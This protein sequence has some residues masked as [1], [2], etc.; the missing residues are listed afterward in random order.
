M[1]NPFTAGTKI[2][3]IQ[4]DVLRPLYTMYPGQEA[5]KFS[6]LLVE[7]GRAI[8]HH[9]PFME[10]VCRS[11]LV[12][13]IFKII[14]LLGGADQLTEEDF[15]RFTSYVNDG[16][17][18]AMVKMLLSADKE[19]TFIDELAELPPDVRE[20]APPMLTKSKSL[21]SD[22]ITG[23]FKEVYDS[24]E[25]TPQKLHDNFAKSDDFINRLAFLAAENQKKIP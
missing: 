18:K 22:F 1:V 25:K 8:S 2:R 14:K 10:E 16:G 17:I 13:I 7:T 5:A 11:H 9:R 23:F 15:T 4:Q 6:W 12:A 24:V 19:K 3:K 20:N 21:H